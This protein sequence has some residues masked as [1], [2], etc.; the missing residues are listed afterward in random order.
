VKNINFPEPF[1][2]EITLN[3]MEAVTHDIEFD[4]E[5]YKANK[6]DFFNHKLE[7]S[8]KNGKIRIYQM[9]KFEKITDN[10]YMI[11]NGNRYIIQIEIET[12]KIVIKESE[13]KEE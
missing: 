2:K 13:F 11:P 3:D 10:N 8:P 12:D 4:I 5:P 6:L 9:T 7:L 1:P